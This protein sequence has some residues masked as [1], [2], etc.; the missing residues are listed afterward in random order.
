MNVTLPHP[1]FPFTNCRELLSLRAR[2]RCAP[3]V[4]M[5]GVFHDIKH[6][7]HVSTHAAVHI[8]QVSVSRYHSTSGNRLSGH[9]QIFKLCLDPLFIL[10][11]IHTP[12]PICLHTC[13][14]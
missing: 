11:V 10:A 12:H 13:L 14:Q 3:Q 6:A 7:I 4:I 9:T 5:V 2:R 1:G 8:G